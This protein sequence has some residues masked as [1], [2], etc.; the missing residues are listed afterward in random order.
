M[1]CRLEAKEN[2]AE[3]KWAQMK[4]EQQQ[5]EFAMQVV[6]LKLNQRVSSHYFLCFSLFFSL[7]VSFSLFD[8]TLTGPELFIPDATK[9]NH[10]TNRS[11]RSSEKPV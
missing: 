3:S 10:Q 7:F 9:F 6:Q 11:K 2:A 4:K 8:G 1:S 5:V